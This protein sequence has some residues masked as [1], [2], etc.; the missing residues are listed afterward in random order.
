IRFV[1]VDNPVYQF[2]PFNFTTGQILNVLMITGAVVFL[3]VLRRRA[4]LDAAAP[5]SAPPSARKLRKK[6]K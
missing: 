6:L 4:R 2:T 3:Y 5:A 1:H